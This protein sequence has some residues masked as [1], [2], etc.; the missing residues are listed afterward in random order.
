MG[1]AH[2]TDVKYAGA[3]NDTLADPEGTSRVLHRAVVRCFVWSPPGKVKRRSP[4]HRTLGDGD[5]VALIGP[6]W[7]AP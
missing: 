5:A 6:W 2:G 7:N 1:A 4:G 3:A